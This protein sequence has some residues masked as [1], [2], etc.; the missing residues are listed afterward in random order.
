M[1]EQVYYDQA[2]R[3]YTVDQGVSVWLDE[4][5]GA[6]LALEYVGF[7]P[8]LG[9]RVIDLILSSMLAFLA[10]ITA[11]LIAVALGAGALLENMSS[12]S[13]L[14]Y[15][16]SL[17]A[18]MGFF[19]AAE[20][21]HGSTPGKMILGLTVRSQDGTACTFAQALKRE[22]GF[23]L[24]SLFFG[25]P[26]LLSMN[27]SKRLQRMGDV[28]AST[29]VVRNKSIPLPNRRTTIEFVAATAVAS[30]VYAVLAVTG[31]LV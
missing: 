30:A 22:V 26:A 12:V 5:P 23:L 31:T 16:V 3:A 1:A 7:G 18:S 24:D 6:G 10:G 29:V 2:G 28:W 4:L 25:L 9:A 19:M 8:R 13:P 21:L 20:S 17:L 14:G 15:G 27:R 11:G